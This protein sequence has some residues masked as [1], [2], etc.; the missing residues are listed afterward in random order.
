[1]DDVRPRERNVVTATSQVQDT[2]YGVP[3]IRAPNWHWLVVNYFFLGGVAGA[4]FVVAVLG[5][6]F[7]NDRSLVRAARY[8]SVATILP[9]PALLALDLG[10][11]DR[12]LH[13]LRI[14]KFRSPLSLGS[15][16]L[17]FMSVFS[18]V[19]GTLQLLEDI[20]AREVLGTFRR[21]IGIVGLPFAYFMSAYTGLL[22]VV[23][24]VPVWAGFSP[25]MGPTFMASA[26]SNTFASISLILGLNGKEDPNTV[27]KLAR[28]ES[29]CLAAELALL[30]AGI[31]RLGKLRKPLTHGKW[32]AFFWLFTY[33]GGV[34]VPLILQITGPVRGHEVSKGRRLGASAMVLTGSYVLRMSVIFAGH[35]SASRPEDYFELT[36]MPQGPRR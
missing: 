3:V 2:Y 25:F 9:C 29:V 30:T 23:T 18:A 16:T 24:N 31:V 22:L 10:R 6:L 28:A 21:T 20:L 8:L 14:V 5:D 7:S 36:K 12:A 35:V 34:L 11:P 1:M 33:F 17:L 4:S 26:F 27:R 19:A 32:G 15:W 13:M